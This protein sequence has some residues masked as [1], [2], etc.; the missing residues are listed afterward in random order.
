MRACVRWK[1]RDTYD[2]AC[3]SLLSTAASTESRV[4]ETTLPAPRGW[5]SLPSSGHDGVSRSLRFRI[6]HMLGQKW[7]WRPDRRGPS[8]PAPS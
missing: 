2:A 7:A 5:E 3:G 8:D 6:V 4:A 1:A